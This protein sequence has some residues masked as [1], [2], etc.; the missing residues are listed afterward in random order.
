MLKVHV[1]EY[2]DVETF[3]HNE[4][5]KFFTAIVNEIKE[6]FENKLESVLVAQFHIDEGESIVTVAIDEEDWHDSLTLA[7]GYFELKEDYEKCS[8]LKTLISNIE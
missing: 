5:T 3:L 8:M 6:G 2:S 4:K 7:L 1:E